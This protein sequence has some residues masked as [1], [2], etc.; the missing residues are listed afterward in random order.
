MSGPVFLS[1]SPC[2]GFE[3]WFSLEI[4]V[5]RIIYRSWAQRRTAMGWCLGWKRL[6]L[7]L[8]VAS[9]LK[10]PTTPT[11][12]CCTTS[13]LVNKAYMAASQAGACLHTMAIMQAYQ[14]DLLRDLD[15]GEGVGSGGRP[16]QLKSCVGPR[17]CLSGLL[18]RRPM[19]SA[20]PWQHW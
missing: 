5:Q 19:P 10:A 3:G 16:M 12:P 14:A 4:R 6:W 2:R 11:K 17:T 8:D 18:R 1:Q 20:P 15:E 13:N 7:S 9:S